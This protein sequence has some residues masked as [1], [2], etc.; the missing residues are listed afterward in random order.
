MVGRANDVCFASHDAFSANAMLRTSAIAAAL[1]TALTGVAANAAAAVRKN[2]CGKFQDAQAKQH[3]HGQ[4]AAQCKRER[5]VT[6]PGDSAH[7]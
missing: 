1:A 7:L 2:R 4:G 3:F 6:A 5:F